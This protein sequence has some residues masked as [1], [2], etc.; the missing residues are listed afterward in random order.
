[1]VFYQMDDGYHSELRVLQAGTAAVGLYALCGIWM[2]AHVAD[3]IPD[4]EQPRRDG[5]VPREIATRYG[6]REWIERLVAARMWVPVD[7]GWLDVDHLARHRN[8]T[9]ETVLAQRARKAERDRR[10]HAAKNKH[11]ASASSS[12]PTPAPFRRD[13]PRVEG[14][15]YDASNDA[16]SAL[17]PPP[18]PL[19][20][21][22]GAPPVPPSAAAA[23][24]GDRGPADAGPAAPAGTSGAPTQQQP[25]AP[26]DA[27]APNPHAEAARAAMQRAAR[28]TPTP[29]NPAAEPAPQAPTAPEDPAA[30]E[31]RTARRVLDAVRRDDP[32]A[33]DRAMA[34]AATELAERGITDQR[35]RIIRAAALLEDWHA[36]NHTDQEGDHP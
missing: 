28:P 1:M 34:Q 13:D 15:S 2:A 30:D 21:G 18:S 11:R 26:P 9:R 17:P 23:A 25:P 22:V 24:Y 19:R 31:H 6:T 33:L 3:P 35:T 20:G 16:S 14:A 27:P 8:Q 36:R 7:G 5:F 10:Y 32:P 4:G 29:T 12:T